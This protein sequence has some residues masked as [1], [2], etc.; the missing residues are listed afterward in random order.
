MNEREKPRIRFNAKQVQKVDALLQQLKLHTVCSEA[1]CPNLGECFASGTATFMILGSRCSRHCK[2]CDVATGKMEAVDPLEPEH[3]AEAAQLLQLKHVVVTSVTRD[4][5]PDG[6]AEQFAKVITALHQAVPKARVEVLIPDFL[7][8]TDAID[9]VLQAKPDIINH[10]LE[11]VRRLSPKVRHRATYERSLEVLRYIKAQAS[12][13][14]TKTGLMLGLGEREAEVAEA[15]DDALAVGVDFLTLGQYL[16][17]SEKHYPVQEYLSLAQFQKYY[18]L[19]KE[20]GFKFV[21]S[22]PQVRS[23]YKAGAALAK[24]SDAQ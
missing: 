17:P 4:D 1:T 2:F 20:K 7:G 14:Y 22:A 18:R 19:G 12:D 9:T 8:N 23:S 11:T 24:E 16:Q 3:L 21:A 6:G 13:I 15:M 10:N 5:L